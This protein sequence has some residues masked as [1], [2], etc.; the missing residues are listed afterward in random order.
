MR[1]FVS[2]RTRVYYL[3]D[4]KHL[5]LFLLIGDVRVFSCFS[6]RFFRKTVTLWALNRKY[7]I[8]KF[9]SFLFGKTGHFIKKNGL[10]ILT[11]NGKI[12]KLPLNGSFDLV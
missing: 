8:Q 6:K 9:G 7:A 12:Q 10:N 3:K 2:S 4:R 1:V 5:Y 11:D